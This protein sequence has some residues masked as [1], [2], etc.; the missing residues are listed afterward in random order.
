VQEILPR[1]S[2]HVVTYGFSA[3]A[4]LSATDVELEGF[5][6]AYSVR[7]QGKKLGRVS[8][9]VPGRHS[10]QNSLAAIAVGLDLEL[11]F[12]TI[13]AE[14]ARFSGADRRFQL[15]G[16]ADGI[17]II[18]DYGHHPSEIVATLAAAKKGFGRRTVVVFQPHR[19]SRVQA[20]L[21]EFGRSFYD[22]DVLAVCD[23]YP[24]GETP[25]PG[26]TAEGVTRAIEEHGHK[27][28]TLVRDL[29]DVPAWL[30]ERAREGDMVITMGAG[31]VYKAGDEFL[32]RLRSK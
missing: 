8:L 19:Y 2:R 22:A 31:S 21:G 5:K 23:I 25:I 7:L 26:I 10:I 28:V 27:D 11:P 13:V 1:L 16:E 24:A 12:E 15:K 20:L 17:M 4:D 14:M 9:R 32:N 18:D 30:K 6:S 3:Q 29:K